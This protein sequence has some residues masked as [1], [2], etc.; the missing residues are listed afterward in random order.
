RSSVAGAALVRP[1]QPLQP[2]GLAEIEP[3]EAA[4][5]RD[6]GERI[7][8][9]VAPLALAEVGGHL[10]HAAFHA[11]ELLVGPSLALLLLV[12]QRLVA[13][14]QAGVEHA[15]GERFPAPYRDP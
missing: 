13:H 1:P 4:A 2:A 7:A 15:V 5:D 9:V 14:Q 8:L 10:R 3:A 11:R 6:V 12:A